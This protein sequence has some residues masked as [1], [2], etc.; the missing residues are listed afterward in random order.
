MRCYR[1]EIDLAEV[2]ATVLF[3][4]SRWYSVGLLL[5]R[6]LLV[7]GFDPL[8]RRRKHVGIV[9]DHQH[10]CWLRLGWQDEVCGS[11][12]RSCRLRSMDCSRSRTV[13]GADER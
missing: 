9:L 6:S 12:R 11:R 10:L 5:Q 1:R 3:G 4:R 13:L 2:L 7:P 8:R